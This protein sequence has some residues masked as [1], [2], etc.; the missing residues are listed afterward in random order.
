MC[1]ILS[2]FFMSDRIQ[3]VRV[4]AEIRITLTLP[5][6]LNEKC[7]IHQHLQCPSV[8]FEIQKQYFLMVL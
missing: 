2:L 1:I 5:L 6:N 8:V 4:K 3:A 7:Y